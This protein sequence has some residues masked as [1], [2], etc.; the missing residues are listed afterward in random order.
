MIFKKLYGYKRLLGIAPLLWSSLFGVLFLS[1]V[2]ASEGHVGEIRYSILTELQFQNIYGREWEL[3]RGQRIPDRSDLLALFF[4]RE[5]VPDA[6]GLFL[7]CSQAERNDGLGNPEGNLPVGAYQESEFKAHNHGGGDHNHNS[8]LELDA[9]RSPDG[10]CL[11]TVCIFHPKHQPYPTSHS[12]AIIQT[13]GGLETR[14]SCITVNAFIKLSES[15]PAPIRHQTEAEATA[16]RR[17]LLNH[18]EFQQ[19][20]QDAIRRIQFER[21]RFAEPKR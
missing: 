4:G 17:A 2:Y 13:N 12:G 5:F 14:P 6:R 7:R 16:Q 19:A 15:P 11:N 1:P 10:G 21:A 9:S 18:P 8:D 20:V 3:M